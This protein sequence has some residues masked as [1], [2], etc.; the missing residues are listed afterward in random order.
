MMKSSA[1]EAMYD[2]DSQKDDNMWR[3]LSYSRMATPGARFIV[4]KSAWWRLVERVAEGKNSL[5]LNRAGVAKLVA[6]CL[7]GK[8]TSA[9]TYDYQKK[10]VTRS[11]GHGKLNWKGL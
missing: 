9:T 5:C 2:C 10:M 3:L 1:L 8:S 11:E 7:P 4:S 6:T